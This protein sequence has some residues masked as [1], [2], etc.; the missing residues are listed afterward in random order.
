MISSV[1]KRIDGEDHKFR[2]TTRAMRALEDA[3]DA[4]I[5]GLLQSLEGEGFRLTKVASIIGQISADG[6]GVSEAE[7]DEIIDGL[8][9]EGAIAVVEKV[10]EAAFPQTTEQA[11]KNGEGAGQK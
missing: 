8:G 11:A 7:A 10:V 9:I 4:S 5:P 2:L 6:A 1:T 3:Y